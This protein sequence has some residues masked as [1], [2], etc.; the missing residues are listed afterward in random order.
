M[1]T[2]D[3]VLVMVGPQ[4]SKQAIPRAGSRTTTRR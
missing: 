1:I 2:E 4:A 3:G